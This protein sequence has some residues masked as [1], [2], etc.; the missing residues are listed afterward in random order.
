MDHLKALSFGIKLEETKD[1]E[2]IDKY[3]KSYIKECAIDAQT[4]VDVLEFF[5]GSSVYDKAITSFNEAYIYA[6]VSESA[7][8]LYRVIKIKSEGSYSS[9]FLKPLDSRNGIST[10]ILTISALFELV[11]ANKQV[12]TADIRIFDNAINV[13]QNANEIFYDVSGKALNASLIKVITLIS[14]QRVHCKGNKLR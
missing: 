1:L 7:K 14:N 11:E 6:S 2:I 9:T 10:D 4:S 5:Y 12:E 8:K 3:Y 13:L